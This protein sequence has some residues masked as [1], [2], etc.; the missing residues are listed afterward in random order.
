MKPKLFQITSPVILGLLAAFFLAGATSADEVFPQPPELQADVQFWL[1]IFSQYSTNEG[2]LH[3]S[4]NLAV[5]YDRLDMPADLTRR[6]RGRRI[7]R[8]RKEVRA[9]LR[10]LASGKRDGLSPE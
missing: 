5:I 6:E 8:R 10:T 1:S 7:D 2:V 4:R 9:V 3:D